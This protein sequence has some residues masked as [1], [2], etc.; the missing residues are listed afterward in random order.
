MIANLPKSKEYLL[1]I[2]NHIAFLPYRSTLINSNFTI[3]PKDLALCLAENYLPA[4]SN[5]IR[6][7]DDY[8][9]ENET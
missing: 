1:N 6:S 3:G 5:F 9:S 7:L 4:I 8:E 2:S